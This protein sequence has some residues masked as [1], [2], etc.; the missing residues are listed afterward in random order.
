VRTVTALVG[1]EYRLH[2]VLVDSVTVSGAVASGGPDDPDDIAESYW[3][4]N[5]QAPDDWDEEF[6]FRA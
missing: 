3:R 1:A 2:G 5:Q 4:S 6:T